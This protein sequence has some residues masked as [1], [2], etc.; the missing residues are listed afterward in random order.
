MLGVSSATASTVSINPVSV[1]AGSTVECD[2]RRRKSIPSRS[3][4][5]DDVSPGVVFRVSTE[6]QLLSSS[7]LDSRSSGGGDRSR[8]SILSFALEG[9]EWDWKAAI[10]EVFQKRAERPARPRSYSLNDRMPAI[11]EG[12]CSFHEGSETDVELGTS[13]ITSTSGLAKRRSS[14]SGSQPVINAYTGSLAHLVSNTFL[15]TTSRRVST[16][17]T[18]AGCACTS[19]GS[20]VTP[21]WRDGW[22][23]DVMLCNACGLRFQKFARR[24]PSCM[25]IPRKEDSLGNRCIKCS[26]LWVVGSG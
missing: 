12:G 4:S 16:H 22:A 23:P 26:T 6:V 15:Q 21:Y 25:Y 9:D 3:A 14:I 8:A 20:T 17:G 7:G 2:A 13:P 11:S 18:A 1:A 19:C 5:K 24:C 10:T